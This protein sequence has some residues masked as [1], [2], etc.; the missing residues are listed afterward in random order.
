ML[1]WNPVT[2]A[3]R[4]TRDDALPTGFP[5]LDAA[6]VPGNYKNILSLTFVNRSLQETRDETT[7]PPSS[8]G[9]LE[10]ILLSR[11]SPEDLNAKLPLCNDQSVP[12]YLVFALAYL[13]DYRMSHTFISP[14]SLAASHTS[15]EREERFNDGK[16][17]T[18]QDEKVS[19]SAISTG[20]FPYYRTYEDLLGQPPT[21]RLNTEEKKPDNDGKDESEGGCAE[22][23]GDAEK[24]IPPNLGSDK[25]ALS[26][27]TDEEP[28]A[29]QVLRDST[30]EHCLSRTSFPSGLPGLNQALPSV[31]Y[32]PYYRTEGELCTGPALADRFFTGIEDLENKE[33]GQGGETGIWSLGSSC[34]VC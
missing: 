33:G 30:S 23:V 3:V 18:K 4:R 27:M 11:D 5:F 2:K 26:S 19:S 16:V 21:Y 14:S 8:P 32:F 29:H 20:Y 12:D 6:W 9:V 31:G 24:T 13:P 25:R 10:R 34:M 17:N 1:S 28:R 7:P 22:D 15:T